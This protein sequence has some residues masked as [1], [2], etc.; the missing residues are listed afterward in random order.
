MN[1][2]TRRGWALRVRVSESI[3]RLQENSEG[4]PMLFNSRLE[5]RT[6]AAREKSNWKFRPK[7]K[8]GLG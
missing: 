4:Y 6:Q 1:K 7:S 5:A 2:S 3:E 8:G